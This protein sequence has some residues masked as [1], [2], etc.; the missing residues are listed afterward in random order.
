MADKKITELNELTSLAND[1][2]VVAVDVSDTT[3]ATSGTDK[4]VKY[5]TIKGDIMGASSPVGTVVDFAGS[6]APTGWLLCD[7]SAVSRTTYANLFSV[8]GTTY[9][10]G[11]GSTTFN[12]PDCTGKV[13]VAKSTDTEFDTLGETGGEKT[14]T[15]VMDEI[16]DAAGTITLHDVANGT[17]IYNTSG[18]FSNSTFVTNKY[19]TGGTYS[20]G[21]NSVSY[22]RFYLGGGGGAHNNLQPYIVLNK[23]IKY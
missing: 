17:N 13:T 8:I 21:A 18:V 19:K 11:D 4:K 20:T 12:L 10:A 5:S 6:S 15:L 7:G 9:G 16:P 3:M 23:I 14:H 2:L 1:D 22:I